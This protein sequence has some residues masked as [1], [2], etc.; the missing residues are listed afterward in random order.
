[1]TRPHTDLQHIRVAVSQRV[2]PEWRIPVFNALGRRTGLQVTVF[3][4]DGP[5]TVK[6][7]ALLK[8]TT[9]RPIHLAAISLRYSEGGVEKLRTFHPALLTHLVAG[10]YDVVLV[11]PSTNLFNDLACYA[12]CRMSNAHMVWWESGGGLKSPSRGRRLM[13]PL[14]RRLIRD[15]A[16]AVTY[17]EA[18]RPYL[19]ATGLKPHQ[20]FTALNSIDTDKV[21]RDIERFQADSGP[22]KENL[23][24]QDGRVVGYV[25]GLERRKRVDTLVEAMSLVQKACPEWGLLVVGDGPERPTLQQLARSLGVR[26]AAFVG[27][28]VSDVVRYLI[29]MDVVVLPGQG[30]LAIN[31]A[32][33]C[34]KPVVATEEAMDDTGGV[35]EFIRHG[36]SGYV[37]KAKAS[38]AELAG[39][40]L[41]LMEDSAKLNALSS[42]AAGSAR[43]F[44]LGRM[45]DGLEGAIRSACPSRRTMTV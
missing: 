8:T 13:E 15:S 43:D 35:H 23:G 38:A 42:E 14:V 39:A 26:R 31:H 41:Q 1:M 27:R 33:A 10:A 32:L 7:S 16:A 18:A 11:E 19:V 20:V 40:L 36:R 34:G 28:H 12:Y 5:G 24:L 22:L 3:F 25:G 4:G 37:L 6:N 30:G 21:A 44:N 29:A 2:L 9:F 17:Y 45:V